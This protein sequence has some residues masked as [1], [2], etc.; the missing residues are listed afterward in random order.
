LAKDSLSRGIG[1]GEEALVPPK[2]SPLL[3]AHGMMVAGRNAYQIPSF[4]PKVFRN[5]SVATL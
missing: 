1:G 5:T 2:A 3:S 4:Y